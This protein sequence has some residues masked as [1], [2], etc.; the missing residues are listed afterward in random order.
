MREKQVPV[1]VVEMKGNRMRGIAQLFI[2]SLDGILC[3]NETHLCF[4]HPEQMD[5]KMLLYLRFER[6]M[7][8]FYPELDE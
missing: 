4:L 3:S 7:D 2:S 5:E 1:D 6:E 8:N